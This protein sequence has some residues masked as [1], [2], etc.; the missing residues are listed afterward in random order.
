MYESDAFDQDTRLELQLR[1]HHLT[2]SSRRYGNM[3]VVI[4]DK[5]KNELSA[6]SDPRG[7]GLAEV[8]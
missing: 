4:W 6:A 8:K 1:G 7:E 3:Q 5:K 2:E